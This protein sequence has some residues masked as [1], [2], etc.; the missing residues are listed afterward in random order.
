MKKTTLILI[1]FVA[2]QSTVIYAQDIKSLAGLQSEIQHLV[3]LT[4]HSIVTVSSKSTHSYIVDKNTGLISFLWSNLEEQTN[5]LELIG[6]GIIYNKDG[7]IITKSSTLADFE[8]IKVTLSDK[9]EFDAEYIGTDEMT[10]LAIIKIEADSLAPVKIGNS[11]SVAVFSFAIVIGN[12][13]GILPSASVGLVNSI[14]DQNT[15]IVTAQINPGS[16]GAGVF[17]IWGEWIGVVSAQLTPDQAILGKSGFNFSPQNGI[18]FPS[19]QVRQITEEI[20][21]LQFSQKGWLGIDID[22]DSLAK[23]KIMVSKVIYGSPAYQSGLKKGD[24]LLKYNNSFFRGIEKFADLIEQTKPGTT[25]SIDFIRDSR[26]LKVFPQ[27]AKKQ[28]SNFN[29]NKPRAKASQF[30]RYNKNDPNLAPIIISHEELRLINSR[31][32]QLEEEIAAL[33]SKLKQPRQ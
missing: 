5:E 27:L 9:R 3:D 8:K 17:N 15:I 25:V 19:N 23:G 21:K 30:E 16:N 32:I 6:S 18:V 12:S 20:I 4:N 7:Y 11:D 10:G 29:P 1:C 26:P 33:K 24:W 31:V 13:M 28:P 14:T 22:N 2:F